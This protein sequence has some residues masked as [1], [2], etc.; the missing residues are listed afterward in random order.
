MSLF[1]TSRRCLQRLGLLSLDAHGT[2]FHLREPVGNTYHRIAISNQCKAVPTADELTTSFATAYKETME[3]YPNFGQGLIEQ[4]S[5]WDRVV[6]STF[7]HAGFCPHP[8]KDELGTVAEELF[9]FY[10][11]ADAWKLYP[12]VLPFL[13]TVRRGPAAPSILVFSNFDHRLPRLLLSMGLGEL[14]D[15]ICHSTMYEHMK[16]RM[17]EGVASYRKVA[18]SA[19]VHVGD[20]AAADFT[21]AVQH[22]WHGFL[23]ARTDDA[24]A[25]IAECVAAAEQAAPAE[26][27]GDAKATWSDTSL[28]SWAV[29]TGDGVLMPRAASDRVLSSLDDFLDSG[30]WEAHV[31]AARAV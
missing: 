27:G 18:P 1:Q 17:F 3:E 26:V 31:A 29:R 19:C 16:P 15:G 20:S 2:L 14:V 13:R 7:I 28:P 30:V 24:R 21:G 10:A 8:A 5:W 12:E 23:L 22:G 9:R 11:T 25:N 4:R 6:E